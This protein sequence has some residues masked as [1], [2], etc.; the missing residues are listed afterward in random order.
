V[1]RVG[2][3]VQNLR[4]CEGESVKVGDSTYT[5]PGTYIQNIPQAT[6][7]DSVVTTILE[8]VRIDLSVTP[9]LSITQG[10]SVHVVPIVEPSGIY[11]YRWEQPG[12]S[13]TDCPDPWASPQ[14]S[15]LYRLE[16]SDPDKVCTRQARVQVYVKPCG[17]E[18]PDA[19]SPNN[20]QLNE[21]FYVYGNSCVKQVRE[22][23]IYNRWGEVV[24]QKS[25]FAASDPS[26]GWDGSY[27]G[28]KTAPGVYPYKIRVELTNGSFL[29]YKGV[30]NLFR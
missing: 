17:V 30:V 25:N 3:F 19:F 7:C 4:I 29:S 5:Q 27:H 24:Y 21:V 20:D 22:M 28:E 26:A 12:L 13:C 15:T 18:I 23:F 1:N 14:Q 9:T 16:V 6:G 2:K 11:V 8:V 10:D